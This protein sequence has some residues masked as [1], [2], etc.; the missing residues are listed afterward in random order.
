MS[1]LIGTVESSGFFWNCQ[2][3]RF[4]FLLNLP[5]ILHILILKVCCDKIKYLSFQWRC[6]SV[7][8]ITILMYIMLIESVSEKAAQVQTSV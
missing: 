1:S 3:T 8:I 6:L 2:I 7:L 5:K 4:I